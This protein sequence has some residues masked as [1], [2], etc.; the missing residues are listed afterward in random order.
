MCAFKSHFDM[1]YEKPQLH[2]VAA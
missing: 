1:Q 2:L